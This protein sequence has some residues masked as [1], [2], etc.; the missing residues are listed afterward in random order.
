M[1]FINRKTKILRKKGVKVKLKKAPLKPTICN[2]LTLSDPSLAGPQQT[3]LRPSN[4]SSSS[5]QQTKFRT[6]GRTTNI[7]DKDM[8]PLINVISNVPSLNI[9]ISS[10]DHKMS[11]S[12]NNQETAAHSAVPFTTNNNSL[13]TARI[14][15]TRE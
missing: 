10:P 15:F 2:E 4:A 11:K 14:T 9:I 6:I 8:S 13:L 1:A 12:N 3:N 5:L 7:S